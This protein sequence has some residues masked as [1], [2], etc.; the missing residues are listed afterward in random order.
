MYRRTLA[1]LT[2]LL[3][4]PLLAVADGTRGDPNAPCDAEQPVC[5]L[6]SGLAPVVSLH[7]RELSEPPRVP[8]PPRWIRH[9]PPRWRALVEQW[10]SALFGP[11]D[12]VIVKRK[13][14][15]VAQNQT[16][17]P[18]R[19]RVSLEPWGLRRAA[20]LPEFDFVLRAGRSWT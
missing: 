9:L 7:W 1:L 12:S 4:L 3:L 5:L 17:K 16:R 8:P 6:D 14:T 19:A 18:V 10:W 15:L 20:R 2:I 13:A 11:P